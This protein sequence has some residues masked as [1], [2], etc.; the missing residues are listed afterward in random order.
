[1]VVLLIFILK[2]LLVSNQQR[3]R[4]V[5]THAMTL[6]IQ[7]SILIITLKTTILVA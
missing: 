3:P 7:V 2:H 1:M 5:E 4:V 6:I